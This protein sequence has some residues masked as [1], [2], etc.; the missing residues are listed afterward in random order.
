MAGL[1]GITLL[2]LY[3][4]LQ[5]GI[6]EVVR[7]CQKFG[8]ISKTF[9]CPVCK[10][11]ANLAY[12]RGWNKK[13]VTWRCSLTACGGEVS[14]RTGTIFERSK[15]P[16][17]TIIRLLYFWSTRRSVDDTAME[18]SVSKKTVTEWY[19]FCRQ[20]CVHKLKV[21]SALH[22]YLNGFINTSSIHY[23]VNTGHQNRWSWSHCRS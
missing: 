18:L 11:Y 22:I 4:I 9:K 16:I 14:V 6:E 17:E 23:I 15:L 13:Q 21:W 5:S 20:I 1:V 10:K 7:F 3:T 2:Q 19:K 12:N 8:L